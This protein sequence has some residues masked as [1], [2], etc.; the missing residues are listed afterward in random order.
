MS[1]E[2]RNYGIDLLRI[3]SMLFVVILHCNF[4]GGLIPSLSSYSIQYKFVWL[5]EI[6]AYCAVDIFALITG[7]VMCDKKDIKI[8]NYLNLWLEVV[9]Y[10]FFVTLIFDIYNTNLVSTKDYIFSFL[11]V[12]N[13][14]W[15]Y[16]T[17]YT[18]LFFLI[19]F[20]NKAINSFNTKQLKILF[21]FIIIAFSF[22]D[23]IAKVFYLN[24]GY[25]LI[26]IILLYVLGAIIK[27][28]NIL[29]DVKT[30]KLFIMMIGLYLITYLY[31]L[32][33][34]EYEFF[35]IKITKDLLISY[36][37]PTIVG[38]SILYVLIFSR[39]KF[40][41][42][43]KKVIAFAA[44]SAFA[45]YILNNHVCVWNNIMNG[46]FSRFAYSSILTIFIYVISFSIIF[47]IG[48]ILID[49]V[50][51]KIFKIFRIYT[52]TDNI[53]NYFNRFIK[54]ID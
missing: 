22:Y 5:S 52:L 31:K 24:N 49:K 29:S 17:I 21:F 48:S 46:L 25:S 53:Q 36:T 23:T 54:K 9:F 7:Y 26:W 4:R 42:F 33:G 13:G 12:T 1:K 50:R 2:K 11:P 6:I 10:S 8:K 38:V 43:L 41:D 18:G 34:F 44:P 32:Y 30:Y 35:N 47:V 40:N 3:V 19:P 14:Q 15:W 27:K 20:L 28:C 51:D 45:V 16:F 39:I 37:S